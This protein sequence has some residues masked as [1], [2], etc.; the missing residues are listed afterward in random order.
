MWVRVQNMPRPDRKP[1]VESFWYW[2]N[3][4]EYLETIGGL[5]AFLAVVTYLAS[6]QAWF[7]L[8]LGSLSSGVEAMMPLP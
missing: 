1:F 3:F 4:S 7:K 2:R 8:F 6:D 5:A